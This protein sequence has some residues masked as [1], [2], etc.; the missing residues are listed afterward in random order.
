MERLNNRPEKTYVKA[1]CQLLFGGYAYIFSDSKWT[2]EL[3]ANL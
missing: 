2:K 1:P 3:K